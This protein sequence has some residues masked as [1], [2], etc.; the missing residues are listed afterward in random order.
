M[1]SAP[2][3]SPLPADG[4]RGAFG[5][6]GGGSFGKRPGVAPWGLWSQL[7]RQGGSR[8]ELD[9][10]GIPYSIPVCFSCSLCSDNMVFLKLPDVICKLSASPY[11]LGFSFSYL[12]K[13][14]RGGENGFRRS[15]IYSCEELSNFRVSQ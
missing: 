11:S 7:S 12:G 15:K 1:G 3:R 4:P 6:V 13:K 5:H 10:T 14:K 9:I 2:G 8:V